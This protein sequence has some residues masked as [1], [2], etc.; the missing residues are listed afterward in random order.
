MIKIDAQ[1]DDG[2][3]GVKCEFEWEGGREDILK[4]LRHLDA[5]VAR[6]GVPLSATEFTTAV[7]LNLPATGVFKE[8]AAAEVQQM[9]I[10]YAALRLVYEEVGDLPRS[11]ADT[12]EAQDISVVL[13]VRG[14][15]L[16][17]KLF[18]RPP[19]NS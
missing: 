15:R 12:V 7:V 5:V 3:K 4:L 10:I 2:S 13:T 17:A 11:I 9:A 16:N 18:G 6:A 1:N 14:T 19:L 8:G